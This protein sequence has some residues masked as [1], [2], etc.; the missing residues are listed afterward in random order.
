MTKVIAHAGCEKTI[1]N[2]LE[3]IITAVD[4]SVDMIEVDTRI[5][6]GKVVLSHDKINNDKN[7]VL[8]EDVLEITQNKPIYF[9][10]DIKEN[11][12][13]QQIYQ[14]LNKYNKVEN[15]ILT[16]G[17]NVKEA[18]QL[19]LNCFCNAE[20]IAGRNIQET[21]S[22][23]EQVEVLLKNYEHSGYMGYNFHF[24]NLSLELFN[25]LKYNNIPVI[26]WTVN[27]CKSI[28]RLLSWGVYGITTDEVYNAIV[29]RRKLYDY[30]VE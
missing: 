14:L 10:C 2:S 13:L 23:E 6:E 17:Y 22:H 24:Q 21:L 11:E 7:S 4:A 16:G 19:G 9:N 18:D 29:I 12:A 26:C 25:E 15:S 3:N 30:N 5:F 8:F 20:Y 27:C 28:E 1:A